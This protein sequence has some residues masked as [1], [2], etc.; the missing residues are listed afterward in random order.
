MPQAEPASTRDAFSL[1]SSAIGAVA[2]VVM[3]AIAVGLLPGFEASQAPAPVP[4]AIEQTAPALEQPAPQHMGPSLIQPVAATDLQK[5]IDGMLI[6]N[7][8]KARLRDETAAGKTRVGWV[9]VSDSVAED[10]DWVIV[11]SAG[12]SQDVRLFHKPTTIAVPYTP[13]VPAVVTGKVDGGGGITVAVHVG[14]ST[15]RLAPMQVGASVQVPT[16]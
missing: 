13:G 16:P 5:A 6:S 7:S 4:L 8:E 14:G 15:F 11:S 10:G 2:L 9:T 3:G 1:R 12:F